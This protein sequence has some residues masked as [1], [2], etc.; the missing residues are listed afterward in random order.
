MVLVDSE[1]VTSPP[2]G[3]F[4]IKSL[5]FTET[6]RKLGNKRVANIV[7]LGALTGGNEICDNEKLEATVKAMAPAKFFMLNLNALKA[8]R[9][10]LA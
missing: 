7:A 4:T 10:L 6:A 9:E 1:L 8:G 3:S 5:P 2:K